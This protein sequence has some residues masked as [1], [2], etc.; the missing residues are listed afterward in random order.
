MG[1]HVMI[2]YFK[3]FECGAEDINNNPYSDE[4]YKL[5]RN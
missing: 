1:Q 5:G 4:Y 3:E 2:E